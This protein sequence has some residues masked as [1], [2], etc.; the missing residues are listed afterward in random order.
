MTP[1]LQLSPRSSTGYKGVYRTETP[2]KYQVHY[3]GDFDNVYLGVFD[4]PLEGAKAYAK[5]ATRRGNNLPAGA[6]PVAGYDGYYVTRDGR[7]FGRHG[8]EMARWR[9][10][11]GYL[12]TTMAGGRG[13]D[14]T[15]RRLGIH[16]IVCMSFH[17]PKPTPKHEVRHLDGSRD[18]NIPSNLCWGTRKENSDDRYIHGT[19]PYGPRKKKN[20]AK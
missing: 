11:D 20:H 19:V 13:K 7:V 10:K 16:V 9:D 3:C 12:H 18:N 14:A 15:R 4:D 8:R 2:G 5:E 17:G 6:V 1:Q